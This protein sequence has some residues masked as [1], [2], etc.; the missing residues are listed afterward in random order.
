[1]KWGVPR[2]GFGEMLPLSPPHSH[3]LP[4]YYL[5][6]N[7]QG[8]HGEAAPGRKRRK[9]KQR[10]DFFSEVYTRGQ[11]KGFI[12]GKETGD[13]HSEPAHG[14]NNGSSSSQL[15]LAVFLRTG[16]GPNSAIIEGQKKTSM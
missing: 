14:V 1:M 8:C 13:G 5:S 3:S 10:S 9:I 6:S 15:T 12:R 4:P 7:S 16:L 11:A 2:K